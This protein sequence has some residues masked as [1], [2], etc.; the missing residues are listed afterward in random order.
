MML[1]GPVWRG[2]EDVGMRC[3]YHCISGVLPRPVHTGDRAGKAFNA[4]M[5]WLHQQTPVIPSE[6]TECLCGAALRTS[7]GWPHRDKFLQILP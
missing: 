7:K 6:T 4:G 1:I 5:M 2:M 3:E